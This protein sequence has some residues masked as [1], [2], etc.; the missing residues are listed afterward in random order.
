M[1]LPPGG[2]PPWRPQTSCMKFVYVYTDPPQVPMVHALY[3]KCKI[4]MTINSG[5]FTVDCSIITI[6]SA[7]FTIN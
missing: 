6:N 7:P 4:V 2:L 1:F 5:L 3:Q